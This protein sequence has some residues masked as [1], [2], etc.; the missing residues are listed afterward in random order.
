MILT[1]ISA[2]TTFWMMTISKL[3]WKVEQIESIVHN[4]GRPCTMGVM[5]YALSLLSRV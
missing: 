1:I 4:K 5:D 2:K 3:L